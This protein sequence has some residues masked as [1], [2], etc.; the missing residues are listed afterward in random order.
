MLAQVR[1]VHV[2]TLTVPLT[3]LG[4]RRHG[5]RGCPRP[6]QAEDVVDCWTEVIVTLSSTST[7]VTLRVLVVGS[8]IP[9][10]CGVRDEHPAVPSRRHHL[11]E[12]ESEL[13]VVVERVIRAVQ[14][15]D[16]A[17]A[18]LKM[19]V[20]ELAKI[21]VEQKNTLQDRDKAL[22]ERDTA[23]DGRDKVLYQS[24]R[25]LE[26]TNAT[27]REMQETTLCRRCNQELFQSYES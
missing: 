5:V 19:L 25:D 26:V 16:A 1:Q 6:S 4:W 7:C 8:G 13:A 18:Q 12:L 22:D 27:I 3:E 14:E 9:V 24:Q 17:N 23:L 11:M 2:G 21:V 15:R 10:K 20:D